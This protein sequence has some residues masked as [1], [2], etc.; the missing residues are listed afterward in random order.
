M[1]R[2]FQNHAQQGLQGR[3][4]GE[5]SAMWGLATNTRRLVLGRCTVSHKCATLH[6][7]DMSLQSWH[8][9]I[10]LEGSES[11]LM[12]RDRETQEGP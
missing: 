2:V 12:A 1:V 3:F 4:G 10:Q 9:F 6:E 8:S 11:L 5:S 7:A